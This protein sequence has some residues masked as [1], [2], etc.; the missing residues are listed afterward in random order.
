MREC[1]AGTTKNAILN[2]IAKTRSYGFMI[3]S[4]VRIR[5]RTWFPSMGKRHDSQ[6]VKEEICVQEYADHEKVFGGSVF[7]CC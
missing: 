7:F 1:C 5:L 2:C 6:P 3:I 4:G